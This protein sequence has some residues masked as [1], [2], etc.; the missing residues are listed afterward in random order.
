MH[1]LFGGKNLSFFMNGLKTIHQ[2]RNLL[3]KLGKNFQPSS[4]KIC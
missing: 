1:Q 2:Q 3:D 4:N